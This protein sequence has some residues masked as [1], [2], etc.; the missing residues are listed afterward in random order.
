MR[1]VQRGSGPSLNVSDTR[2]PTGD[3][4][5]ARWS[6]SILQ[7]AAEPWRPGS[8]AAVVSVALRPMVTVDS[9]CAA[10]RS[11][12][13][14]KGSASRPVRWRP[15]DAAP[16]AARGLAWCEQELMIYESK[17]PGPRLLDQ[18]RDSP[19]F[20]ADRWTR[21]CRARRRTASVRARRRT[22]SVRARWRPAS[23]RGVG[24]VALRMRGPTLATG[25]WGDR[26]LVSRVCSRPVSADGR[27]PGAGAAVPGSCAGGLSSPVGRPWVAPPLVAAPPALADVTL[28]PGRF[29][30]P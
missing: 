13:P 26:R 28:A 18:L 20:L 2:R 3:S 29:L 17:R 7:I 19:A 23:A 9:P 12:S 25:G 24:G 4:L 1:G 15:L 8:S 27:F 21:P 14:P 10:S 30:G 11:K 6:P 5:G 16:N 22:A